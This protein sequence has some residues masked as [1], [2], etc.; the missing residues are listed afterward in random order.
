MAEDWAIGVHAVA[1][2]IDAGEV[3]QLWVAREREED[4]RI[5]EVVAA[6][7]LHGIRTRWAATAEINRLGGGPQHQGLVARLLA[8]PAPT[9]AQVL[10]DIPAPGLLLI[11]DGILD[12]HNLGACLRSAEAAGANAVV[13]PKD[14]AC[15]VNATVRKA[16]AGAASRLPIVVVTNLVRSMVGLQEYGYWIAGLA[17]EASQDLYEADLRGPLAL[18]LGSEEKGL[19]RLVREHCDFLWHIPMCG[20]VE[21]LNVSVAGALA[22]FEARR[23]RRTQAKPD[24]LR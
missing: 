16:A 19:R 9:L 10:E 2:A 3:E 24:E 11:L 17:G 20:A 7:E 5:R 15:P 4:R 8:R 22:L 18:V 14:H 23:Q 13:L 6:A 1:A 21:S 12:P